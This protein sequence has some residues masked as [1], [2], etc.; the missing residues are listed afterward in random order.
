[1]EGSF[2]SRDNVLQSVH[3]LEGARGLSA[4]DLANYTNK[5]FLATMQVLNR[6]PTF[7][8][9]EEGMFLCLRAEL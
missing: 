6:L 8:L 5:A 2:D 3:H 9:G 1:M 7:C 4:D